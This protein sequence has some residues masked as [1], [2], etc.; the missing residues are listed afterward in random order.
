MNGEKY[1]FAKA[2]GSQSKLNICFLCELGA[3]ARERLLYQE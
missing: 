1:T 3:F 2:L